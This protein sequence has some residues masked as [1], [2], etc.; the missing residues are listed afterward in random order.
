MPDERDP[1]SRPAVD[2]AR[3]LLAERWSRQLWYMSEPASIGSDPPVPLDANVEE[4]RNRLEEGRSQGRGGI[5]SHEWVEVVAAL[6][7]ELSTRVR[8][9]LAVGPIV[10]DG[11]L[12]EFVL[13]LNGRGSLEPNPAAG[14][15]PTVHMLSVPP[16][17]RRPAGRS[18]EEPETMTHAAARLADAT[19]SGGGPPLDNDWHSGVVV[20]RRSTYDAIS[21]LLDELAARVTPGLAVGP[22]RSDDALADLADEIASYLH[23]QRTRSDDGYD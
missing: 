4:W 8:P 6:L 2:P 18:Q 1:R 19:A 5:S 9:G 11:S 12:Q 21:E 17:Y 20:L 7:R 15:D 22:I 3:Y 13:E 10:S 14:V 23:G 16:W